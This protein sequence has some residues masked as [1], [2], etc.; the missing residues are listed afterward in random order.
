MFGIIGTNILAIFLT[1]IR[2][3]KETIKSNVN[4][5]VTGFEVTGY[6][7]NTKMYTFWKQRYGKN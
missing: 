5:D 4:N 2:Y 7:K 6:T 1:I 3:T